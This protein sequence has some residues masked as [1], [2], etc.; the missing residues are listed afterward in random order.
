MEPDFFFIF[1][2]H[3][4]CTFPGGTYSRGA[5]YWEGLAAAQGDRKPNLWWCHSCGNT[6]RKRPQTNPPSSWCVLAV[7][8]RT[9][10]MQTGQC[11]ILKADSPAENDFSALERCVIRVEK[12]RGGGLKRQRE[13]AHEG[14]K[15]GQTEESVWV[16]S[17]PPAVFLKA[18]RGDAAILYYPSACLPS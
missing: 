17:H 9:L 14:T 3:P 15:E 10:W 8:K 6:R 12:Q 18:L 11:Q 7:L 1:T 4:R 16:R 5:H 2:S 13:A